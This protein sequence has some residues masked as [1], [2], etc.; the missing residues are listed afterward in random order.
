MTVTFDLLSAF[1]TIVVLVFAALIF[2]TAVLLYKKIR[3]FFRSRA[4]DAFDR[5]EMRKRWIEIEALLA[6][7]GEVSRKLA[8][9]EADK[10]LDSALKSLAMPGTTLGERLKFA[11]YKYAKLRD[12]WWAHKV[13]NQLAHEASYHLDAGVARNAVRAF[14]RALEELGV[15]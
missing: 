4:F 12:V 9:I 6:A 15:L 13:R 2:G 14:K 5:E 8:I 10:L 1:Q 3:G 7:P 11:Q